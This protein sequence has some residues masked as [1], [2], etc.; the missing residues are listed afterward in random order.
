[1]ELWMTATIAFGLSLDALAVAIGIGARNGHISYAPIIRLSCSFGLFQF[2]M[3]ILGW[4]AGQAIVN[5]I[6]SFDHWV[7]FLILLFVGLKMIKEGLE[8]GEEQGEMNN[9]PTKGLS[10]LLLSLATS[11]DSLAVGF[12]FSLINI[13]IW[14]PAVIIG[15]MC[16]TVTAVGM[17]FGRILARLLG[18]KVEILGG[19]VLIAIGI[20]ILIDHL[21]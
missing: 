16:F 13:I 10:L 8:E 3:A 14:K 15:L 19:L 4:F 18:R 21:K 17:L 11:I 20:K 9:D 12:S 2:F 5:W 1:M 7:A 6:A